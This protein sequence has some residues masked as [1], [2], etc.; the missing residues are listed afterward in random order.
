MHKVATRR[1]SA[2]AVHRC[3]LPSR[4]P[5]LRLA[6]NDV[7]A[8]LRITM[9][10]RML[11]LPRVDEKE[12]AIGATIPDGRSCELMARRGGSGGS[13]ERHGSNQRFSSN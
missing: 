5:A 6:E 1:A 8:S 4:I 13:H 9:F 12:E 7:T 10:F 3:A 11:D 2:M